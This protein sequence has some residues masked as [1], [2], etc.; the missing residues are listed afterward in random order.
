MVKGEDVVKT[1]EVKTENELII[2]ENT[3]VILYKK[4]L[5]LIEPYL[6]AIN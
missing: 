1:E 5:C 3:L 4:D 6:K 2:A